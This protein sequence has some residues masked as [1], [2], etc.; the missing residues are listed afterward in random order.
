MSHPFLQRLT[1]SGRSLFV[2]LCLL[3]VCILGFFFLFNST[4]LDP[5]SANGSIGPSGISSFP[6]VLLACLLGMFGVLSYDHIRS[7]KTLAR[8]TA[9]EVT[10]A[11]AGLCVALIIVWVS[12][13]PSNDSLNLLAQF[14]DRDPLVNTAIVVT[15]LYAIL[16]LPLVPLLFLFFP[17]SFIRRH[18][19][20]LVFL[21]MIFL[22]YLF[23]SVPEAAY[24]HHIGPWTVSVTQ[25]ILN[26]LP[27]G[28]AFMDRWA[29]SY[30]GFTAEFGYSCSE[31]SAI[32]L[33]VGLFLFLCWKISKKRIVSAP[34][35]LA[36][37]V[38]GCF[39]IVLVNILRIVL[40]MIVGSFAPDMGLALFH[41]AA[42][43]LLLFAFCV[44]Y[45][46]LILPHVTLPTPAPKKAPLRKPRAK[47]APVPRKKK[48]A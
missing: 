46:R 28:E 6:L 7:L 20:T 42:G 26:I 38:L 32:V 43:S 2:R 14:I 39:L 48:K 19:L 35:A 17:S 24:Y 25:S 31:F 47:K 10:G 5:F 29:L 23:G 22:A 8:P 33:F 45:L 18:A 41:G 37:A 13:H 36:A 15:S 9:L 30:N 11:L 27:G 21:A 16:L 44:A 12:T 3:Y 34:H 40:I 4:L 1:P